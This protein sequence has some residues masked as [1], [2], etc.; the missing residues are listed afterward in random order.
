VSF[1]SYN[2][3]D[4]IVAERSANAEEGTLT[5]SIETSPEFTESDVLSF[6]HENFPSF[7]RLVHLLPAR[8]QDIVLSYYVLGAR[9]ET[10]GDMHGMTQT[11]ASQNLRLLV[12]CI[13]A[14][15]IFNGP[16]NREQLD[17]VFT[18][19]GMQTVELE[20]SGYAK[21]RTPIPCNLA[22]IVERYQ[23]T[24]SFVAVAN[25]LHVWRP[26]LRRA[27]RRAADSLLGSANTKQQ[28]VGAWL[29]LLIEKMSP[30]GKGYTKKFH[31]KMRDIRRSD[32]DIVGQ[33]RIK[34]EDKDF[35]DNVFVSRANV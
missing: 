27:L 20:P 25:E 13:A 30:N 24:K 35:E 14:L 1:P 11:V 33:F 6:M 10:V 28:A 22:Q 16:P 15:I 34:V 12:K 32:P 3:W 5:I 9:Q 26:E 4:N 18:Q 7:L 31:A 21:A 19:A 8:S 2:Y 23:E 17:E 29:T